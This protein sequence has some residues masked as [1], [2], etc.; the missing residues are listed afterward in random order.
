MTILQILV[1]SLDS[2]LSLA[3]TNS[4]AISNSDLRV[5]AADYQRQ[6]AIAA[7]FPNVQITAAAFHA[8]DPMLVIGVSDILGSSENA[9]NVADVVNKAG[10]KFDVNTEY[11]GLEHGYTAGVTLLQPIFAGGRI[12]NGNRL[13]KL[14][15]EAAR[16][17]RDIESNN[18]LLDVEKAFWQAYSLRD[19]R[20][21]IDTISAIL[22]TLYAD[23]ST[24]CSAGLATENDLL[25]VS[26]KRGELQSTIL[27]LDNGIRLANMNLLNLIGVTANPDSL[28]LLY[29]DTDTG[30]VLPPALAVL[31]ESRLLDMQVEA[32]RLERK[33]TMGE[34]L[35]QVMLGGTY[36]YSQIIGEGRLNGAAFVTLNIPLTDWGKTARKMQRQQTEI[37]MAENDRRFLDSQ[38]ELRTQMLQMNVATAKSQLQLAADNLTL[39]RSSYQSANANYEAGIISLSEL[40]QVNASHTQALMS[41]TD[42]R[43]ALQIA[44]SEY[45]RTAAQ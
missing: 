29:E 38:L 6:E 17:Q 18:A 37:E 5:Q 12:V 33:M 36:G 40:L 27:Q 15:S 20:I 3:A 16:V 34:A 1:L 28:F 30:S 25:Q 32:K 19:K 35:P 26:L 45:L 11:R 23:I 39:A 24:A 4:A 14:G 2:I 41:Y 8:L 13:A 22:D 43:I 7:Y 10:E 31:P 42:A 44:I 21:A 9:K